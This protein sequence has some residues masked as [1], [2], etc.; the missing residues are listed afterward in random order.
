[1]GRF[2][3]HATRC[4]MRQDALRDPQTAFYGQYGVEPPVIAGIL[5]RLLVGA[6]SAVTREGRVKTRRGYVWSG[7]YSAFC[8]M[9]SDVIAREK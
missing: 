9:D 3:G 2:R 4:R 8:S 6:G 7:P 5:C 1:M